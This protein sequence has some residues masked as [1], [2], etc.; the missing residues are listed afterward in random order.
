[1]KTIRNFLED[2]TL[3]IHKFPNLDVVTLY[4]TLLGDD[5]DKQL[6]S[7]NK[8]VFIDTENVRDYFFVSELSFSDELHFVYTVNSKSLRFEYL[9][10]ITNIG[11]PSFF[12]K[13]SSGVA[14]ALDFCLV[15]ILTEYIVENKAHLSDI[16]IYIVSNDKG[17]YS[18][19][20]YLKSKY[21]DLNIF[22][23]NVR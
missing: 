8:I 5:F 21:N 18:A 19:V 9:D 7:N 6:L 16:N 13:S 17:F 15:C 12:Y 22:I 2:N 14:N 4:N 1:M 11:L 23:V 20:K 3:E 10:Y